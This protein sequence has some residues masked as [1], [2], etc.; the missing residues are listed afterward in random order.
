[1][2]RA[3]GAALACAILLARVA[4]FADP[5]PLPDVAT[6]P[7][8]DH[9]LLEHR[10]E[11]AFPFDVATAL[12]AAFLAATRPELAPAGQ[13]RALLR[14]GADDAITYV[15]IDAPMIADRDVATRVFIERD[16]EVAR[17]RW[18]EA[19]DLAPPLAAGVVR[20]A[21][22][23]GFLELTPDGPCACRVVHVAQIDPGEKLPA[24]LSRIFFAKQL[25]AQLDQVRQLGS[26]LAAKDPAGCGAG[27]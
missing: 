9:P 3:A 1:M 18:R 2:R 20:I 4:A 5:A 23:R 16:G 25:E 24:W 10:A 6:A 8:A 21:R 22:S 27:R 26:E 17:V 7:P 15:R 11:A 12:R 14:A 13:R 19:N